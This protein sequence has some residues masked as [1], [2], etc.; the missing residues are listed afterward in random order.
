MKFVFFPLAFFLSILSFAA[1]LPV[2][3]N[4]LVAREE[5][6]I[7]ED[8]EEVSAAPFSP[9]DKRDNR[10]LTGFLTSLNRSGVG[11]SVVK[12][13]I[14]VPLTQTQVI[15][16]IGELIKEKGLTNLL[17]VAGESNLAL[18]L[19]L[20]ILTHYET[21]P[22]LTNVVNYYK[23][24]NGGK[25]SSTSSLF[26]SFSNSS[27]S[28]PSSSPTSS[29]TSN[30]NRRPGGLIGGLL[31]GIFG[32]GSSSSSSTS[33]STSSPSSTGSSQSSGSSPRR[34]GLLGGL[35]N[36]VLGV[37]TSSP[38]SSNSGSSLGTSSTSS[39][40]SSGSNSGSGLG[41]LFRSGSSAS[42]AAQPSA[43]SPQDSSLDSSA[44]GLDGYGSGSNSL[45]IDDSSA[46]NTASPV[47]PTEVA[48][49]STSAPTTLVTQASQASLGSSQSSGAG[50]I[51]DLINNLLA[52]EDV[53]E[54]IQYEDLAKRDVEDLAQ[55][56]GDLVARSQKL[57]VV[58]KRD[59]LDIL[60][61]QLIRLIGTN[62]N[63]QDIA[64]SLDKSGIAINVV[65]NALTDLGWY[66]FDA[67][68]I[69]YLVNQKIVTFS[70][71]FDALIKSGVVFK[72]VGQIVAN[73]DYV[74]LVIN[75]V[76]AIFTGKINIFAL[77]KAFF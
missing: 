11:V 65:Y 30:S 27:S 5:F 34:G 70:S 51:D 15:H 26:S 46:A 63:V 21:I 48:T 59:L 10:L 40:S 45:V 60:Y 43:S 36:G 53:E 7:R 77:V 56:T 61:S 68:L 35:L 22:G 52:R 55:M 18:D 42:A 23:K 64:E 3:Y 4:G 44:D 72:V 17:E 2:L 41:S 6:M 50:S 37:F 67:N 29:P 8:I 74:K 12:T 69:S 31:G 16:F 62:S 39:A 1:A 24:N 25:S 19:V 71:L 32:S 66:N 9:L 47:V 73:N 49:A 13:A 28:V 14:S 76:V 38:S 57:S 33:D 58:E 20:L 54:F 75:F